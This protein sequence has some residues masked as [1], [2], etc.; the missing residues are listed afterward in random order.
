MKKSKNKVYIN[1]AVLV[2][3]VISLGF[4]Y[5]VLSYIIY[6]GHKLYQTLDEAKSLYEDGKYD[7]AIIKY[8][9]VIF[10]DIRR[11]AHIRSYIGLIHCYVAKRDSVRSKKYLAKRAASAYYC[12]P[13]IKT[14][15]NTKYL[16]A[17][18][19]LMDRDLTKSRG[20]FASINGEK[21]A[22][23]LKNIK[24]SLVDYEYYETEKEKYI[25]TID[26][27]LSI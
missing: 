18:K 6:D 24:D 8:K 3:V 1:V 10:F 25:D 22:D 20:V 12:H 13:K 14:P 2:L 9:T 19:L 4:S 26:T 11:Q 7:D 17:L 16:T 15:E 5:F 27:I 23:E 21:L